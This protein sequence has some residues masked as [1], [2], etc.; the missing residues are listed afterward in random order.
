MTEKVTYTLNGPTSKGFSRQGSISSST[1]QTYLNTVVAELDKII[2][3][4]K[5]KWVQ[6]IG[7]ILVFISFILFGSLFARVIW[8]YF[9]L[10]GGFLVF[11]IL[12]D[13]GVT[14]L[15][16]YLGIT[17]MGPEKKNLK[18]SIHAAKYLNSYYDKHRRDIEQAI[19]SYGYRIIWDIKY[20]VE[21]Q[22]EIKFEGGRNRKL[23]K[24]IISSSGCFKV[25]KGPQAAIQPPTNLNAPINI[26]NVPAPVVRPHEPVQQSTR[27]Q[28]QPIR[29][30]G[31]NNIDL[32]SIP[33][34]QHIGTQPK[35]MQLNN[36]P[37]IQE[38]QLQKNSSMPYA[39]QKGG[40]F[41]YPD[42]YPRKEG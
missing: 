34:A 32:D 13:I 5:P 9:D 10:V 26:S 42:M 29:P 1:C 20:R 3:N 28:T 39:K 4:Q 25:E 16:L 33:M 21:Q 27:P 22:E 23:K 19:N 24:K 11:P 14:G 17:L 30:A 2:V 31:F 35:P 15:I 18:N 40:G 12:G 38:V 37:E 7:L 41:N 6:N 36:L 8:V